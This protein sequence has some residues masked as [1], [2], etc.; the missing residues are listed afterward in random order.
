MINKNDFI[1]LAFTGRVKEGD[2]FDTNIKEDAEKI[3]LKLD[4]KPFIICVGQDMVIKGFDKNLEEKEIGKKYSIEID[5]DEAFGKRKKELVKLMPIK[6]F[7]EKKVNPMPG[8]TLALDNMIVKIISVSGGRVLVDFNNPIAGKTVIY[9]FIIKRKVEDLNEKINAIT[10]FILGQTLD[11]KIEEKKIVFEIEAFYEPVIKMLNERF[12]D[13]L[14]YEMIL[15][16]KAVI[17]E[18]GVKISEIN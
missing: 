14:G 6:L 11:F 12:K 7:L 5:Q 17:T 8:M 18:K 15:K 16:P 4:E 13:M 1:E 3:N 10:N 9:D 2:I